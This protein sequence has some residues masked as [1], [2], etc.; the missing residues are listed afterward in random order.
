MAGCV[1]RLMQASGLTLK[2]L[3]EFLYGAERP[4]DAESVYLDAFNVRQ[5]MARDDTEAAM[6]MRQVAQCRLDRGLYREAADAGELNLQMDNA[7]PDTY[8]LLI[9]A[10]LRLRNESKSEEYLRALLEHRGATARWELIFAAERAS[11]IYQERGNYPRAAEAGT[12]H[13]HTGIGECQGRRAAREDAPAR[14]AA[15]DHGQDGRCQSRE[16]ARHEALHGKCGGTGHGCWRSVA[17]VGGGRPDGRDLLRISLS[18]PG[19][20]RG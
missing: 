2:E 4:A 18:I 17:G 11:A 14:P 7:T 20:P 1:D 13:R 16:L 9:E 10:H 3:A 8:G 19:Q 5:R 6:C 12:G 15:S